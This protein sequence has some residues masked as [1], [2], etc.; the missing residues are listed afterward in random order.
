[1]PI[2]TVTHDPYAYLDRALPNDPVATYV[3]KE[4]I[5]TYGNKVADEDGF[6]EDGFGFD[7]FLDIINPLQHIPGISSLYREITGDELSP[8]ARNIGGMIYGGAIGLAVS[9]V[10]SAIEDVT[11]KDVGAHVISLFS[12]DEE[13]AAPTEMI[14]TAPA[15]AEEA[16]VSAAAPANIA[17]VPGAVAPIESA[18]LAV[19]IAPPRDLPER[20][21][22][23]KIP[24]ASPIG[25]E[26]KGDKPA[27]LQQLEK[28]NAQDLTEEQLHAVFRSFNAAPSALATPAAEAKAASAA[29]QKTTTAMENSARAMARPI[30]PAQRQ[31][32]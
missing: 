3:P 29:Y 24:A 2:N 14:A 7:D 12:T 10:N 31:T 1:M 23:E 25:L 30:E 27:L 20:A 4:R 11:G 19:P 9:V 15:T 26:W 18:P 6:G 32:P 13:E 5:D 21:I 22:E 17:P 8:G 28:A 16:P